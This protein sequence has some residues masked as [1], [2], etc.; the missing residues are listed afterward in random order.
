MRSRTRLGLFL[1]AGAGI[2]AFYVIAVAQLPGFGSSAHPYR[3]LAVAAAV[4]HQSANVVSAVNFDQRA[5]DTLV[6]ESI[7]LASVLGV[8]ALLRRLDGE[9]TRRVPEVGQILDST[10]LLGYVLLPVTAI[11]GLDLVVHGHLTP[12]GGF[13]GGVVLGTGLHLLYVAGSFRAVEGIRP[14]DTYRVMEAVGAAGYACLG[15]AGSFAA[16]SFLTNLIAHGRFG[17]LFSAGTVPI[18]NGLV[19][20]EVVAGVVVLLASF[21]DQ[22]ILVGGEAQDSP[23]G[24]DGAA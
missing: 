19:G 16:G 1:T 24:R 11:V 15:V 22:E 3:D 13:Q 20:V 5:L 23:G 18:L 17:H 10:R 6:E 8:A 4:A 12:G 21:L 7:M 2:A 9:R 14:L